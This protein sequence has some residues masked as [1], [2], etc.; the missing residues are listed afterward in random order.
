MYL[1]ILNTDKLWSM[2]I[3]SA[4]EG[5]MISFPE[6]GSLPDLVF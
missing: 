4:P 6:Y 2:E 5:Q 1:L 3:L